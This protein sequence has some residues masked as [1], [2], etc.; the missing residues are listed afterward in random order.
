MR[1]IIHSSEAATASSRRAGSSPTCL[2]VAR[3]AAPAGPQIYSINFCHLHY[4][5]YEC[6]ALS[7]SVHYVYG[8]CAMHVIAINS[9]D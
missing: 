3:D 5:H 8:G 9:F 2:V 4:A 6:F 7:V 1:T